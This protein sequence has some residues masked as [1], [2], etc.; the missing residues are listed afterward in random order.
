M[1]ENEIQSCEDALRRLAAHLD[2]ELERSIH[3]EMERHLA[4]CR[5]CWSRAQFEKR[6]REQV[7]ALG[8]EPVRP[9]LGERVR[10][11]IRKFEVTGGD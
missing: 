2:G 4:R 8:R 9:E 6:L 7:E 10:T 11:L 3:G 1:S 5:S